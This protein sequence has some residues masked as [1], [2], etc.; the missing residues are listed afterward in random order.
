M[1]ITTVGN[2]TWSGHTAEYCRSCGKLFANTLAGDMH[3]TG[4]HGVKEGPRRRRCLTTEE[5]L[6]KLTKKGDKPWFD[7]KVNKYGTEVWR[8]NQP[9]SVW[10]TAEDS[11]GAPGEGVLGPEAGEPSGTLRNAAA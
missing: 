5:M 7:V 9:E 1:P 3:R 6:A 8:R 10:F 4:D 11:V 2:A